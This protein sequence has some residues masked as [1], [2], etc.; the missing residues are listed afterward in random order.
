MIKKMRIPKIHGHKMPK[1]EIAKPTQLIEN[2]DF[3]KIGR[4]QFSYF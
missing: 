1:S 4:L 2:Q 3:M